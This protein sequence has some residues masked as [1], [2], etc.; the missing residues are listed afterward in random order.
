METCKVFAVVTFD[1]SL[2]TFL[3][4]WKLNFLDTA[5]IPV[6]SLKPS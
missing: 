2:E 6:L 4:E 3:V 5:G 1:V